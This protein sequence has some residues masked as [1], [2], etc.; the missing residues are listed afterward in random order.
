LQSNFN[1]E[2]AGYT[3]G[4][5][6]AVV[7]NTPSLLLLLLLLRLLLRPQPPLTDSK[8]S[9]AWQSSACTNHPCDT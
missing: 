3:V 4:C 1:R 7:G 8:R 6:I 5:R 2:I 9:V